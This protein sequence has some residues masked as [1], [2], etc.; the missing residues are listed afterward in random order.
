MV[1]R[2][3]ILLLCIIT[4]ASPIIICMLFLNQKEIDFTNKGEIDSANK[5]ELLFV[6][7]DDMRITIPIN[8]I[9]KYQQYLDEQSDRNLE[10]QRTSYDFLDF[11]RSDGSIFILLKY[12]CGSKLC[13]TLLIKYS[14][15]NISS[16]ALGYGSIF[17]EAKQSPNSNYAAFLYGQN[18]GNQILR[19]N[20]IAVDLGRMELLTS[21]N[22][23]LANTYLSN[24][25]WPIIDFNWTNDQTIEIQSADILN[26]DYDSLLTWYKSSMKTKE[27]QLNFQ[28]NDE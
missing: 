25:I 14:S 2:K 4:I 3:K 21:E 17:M 5:D 10:I 1:Q 11:H 23:D 12:S 8:S 6:E 28:V 26:S 27:V 22:N 9:P 7:Q 15:E 18:E 20:L 16:I 13:S 19:N 24:A